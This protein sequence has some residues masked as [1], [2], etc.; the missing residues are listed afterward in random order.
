M[1]SFFFTGVLEFIEFIEFIDLT[2]YL[3]SSS[4]PPPLPRKSKYRSSQTF[5]VRTVCNRG[6]GGEG[7]GLC[8][9]HIQE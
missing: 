3:L 1:S 2:L 5:Y 7:I 4:P 6:V 8:G 9:E